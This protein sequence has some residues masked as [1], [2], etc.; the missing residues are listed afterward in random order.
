MCSLL[1][2]VACGLRCSASGTAPCTSRP[3]WRVC[4]QVLQLLCGVV[5]VSAHGLRDLP[6]YIALAQ[7][8]AAGQLSGQGDYLGV[9]AAEL[10]KVFDRLFL[11][12]FGWYVDLCAGRS[13]SVPGY[14][15]Y[16]RRL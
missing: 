12:C 8:H 14:V 2:S 6:Q 13:T 10:F 3:S 4:G 7:L 15:A 11:L 5:L 1:V 9:F 16:R